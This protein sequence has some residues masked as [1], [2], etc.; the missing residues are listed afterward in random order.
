MLS[1]INKIILWR[2]L[3]SIGLIQL[4]VKYFFLEG[5]GFETVLNNELLNFLILATILIVIGNYFFNAHFK[6]YF[7]VVFFSKK[8]LLYL[9][10]FFTFLGIIT[11]SYI[12]FR[13]GKPLYSLMFAFLCFAGVFYVIDSQRKTLLTNIIPAFL[14]PLCIIMVWWIDSPVSLDSTQW[15]LFLNIELIVLFY[16]GAS[17][18]TN[19]CKSIV[20]DLKNMKRDVKRKSETLP[21]VFGE[22]KTKTIVLYF[23]ITLITLTSIVCFY[24][25]NRP[26][27]LVTFIVTMIIP[28]LYCAWKLIDSK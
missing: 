25:N 6:N 2:D 18:I 5:F 28:Q 1:D 10:M 26:F 15:Q 19:L 23:N 11:G 21:L 14:R 9:A 17:F 27:I 12:S 22:K 4:F 13:I 8:Q 20:N 3:I 24:F 16:I 7:Q